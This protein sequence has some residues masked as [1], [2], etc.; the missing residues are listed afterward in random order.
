MI[1][2]FEASGLLPAGIHWSTL[3]EI[4]M[5]YAVNNH[6]QRLVGGLRRAVLA[7]TTAGCRTLYLDGSFITSKEF[8]RDYDACWEAG[9]VKLRL[10]D[11]VFL[12]FSNTRAA[13][14]A[15]FLGEFFPAH[16]PAAATSPYTTFLKF[17][18]VD[19]D[20][21]GRKGIIGLNL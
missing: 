3:E 12:D 4:E 2:Q 1:P 15:K 14:K 13:Q 7:L 9:G 18:Q 5:R 21:G 8:P 11:L 20:T 17:F 19:K 10:L 16:L 6:R